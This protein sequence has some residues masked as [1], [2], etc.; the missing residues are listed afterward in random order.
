MLPL[1]RIRLLVADDNAQWR[2][3]IAGILETDY[4]LVGFAVRGDEVLEAAQRL[5][6]DAIT[7]DVAMP[8]E[9]GLKVLPR[10]RALF[11]NAIIVI[12]TT[13]ATLLFKEAALARG[14]DGYV[15]K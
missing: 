11:P 7:L 14:A 6:P 2:G 5:R 8:G 13:C 10:L 15:E 12:V 9:S 1:P 4:D 3:I